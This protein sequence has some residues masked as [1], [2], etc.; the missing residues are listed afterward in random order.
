MTNPSYIADP[1]WTVVVMNSA[2]ATAFDTRVGTSCLQR[3]FTDPQIANAHVHQ[4]MM[5][6]SV[7]AQFRAQSARFPDDPRFETIARGLCAVSETFRELWLRQVVSDSYH[8]DVV[9]DHPVLGRLS[10]DPMVFEVPQFPRL[11]LFT[12][13]PKSGTGTQAALLG[14]NRKGTAERRLK[15]H[16]SPAITPIDTVSRLR[17]A[18]ISEGHAESEVTALAEVMGAGTA[19]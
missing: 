19:V 7:V 11:R 12:Y 8:I 15:L 3:F 17:K 2:A 4:E 18:S 1:F 5:A 16:P 10:F 6:R 14:M 9:Y 13:L